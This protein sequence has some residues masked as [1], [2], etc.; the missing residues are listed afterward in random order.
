MLQPNDSWDEFEWEQNLKDG[1]QFAK[2]YF[3]LLK[4]FR[5]LPNAKELIET[6]MGPE[7]QDRIAELNMEEQDDELFDEEWDDEQYLPTQWGNKTSQE[8]NHNEKFEQQIIGKPGDPFFYET[9]PAFTTLRQIN[10]SWCNIYAAIL[11]QE[12]RQ[13]GLAILF[14]LGRSLANLIYSVDD[15]KLEQVDASIAF[16][17]RSTN[18]LNKALGKILQ[19]KNKYPRL[20]DIMEAIYTQLLT[21][22]QH[23]LDQLYLCRNN[24][25]SKDNK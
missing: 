2:K 12:A 13:E 9:H 5:D 11:P 20:N 18:Q 25:K 24:N 21:A 3:Q 14:H 4:R 16:A 22:N 8:E 19:M 15:G 23:I 1:D 10:L 17:K 7:F 6:Y